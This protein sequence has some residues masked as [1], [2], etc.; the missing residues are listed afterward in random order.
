MNEQICPLPWQSAV[1]YVPSL[2][3]QLPWVRRASVAIFLL[4]WER[5]VQGA[6]QKHTPHWDAVLCVCSCQ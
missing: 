2:S 1:K 5:E 6:A 3:T 4:H